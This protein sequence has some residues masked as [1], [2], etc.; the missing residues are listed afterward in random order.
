VG[1][2]VWCGREACVRYGSWV[3]VNATPRRGSLL[4]AVSIEEDGRSFQGYKN[5]CKKMYEGCG[6]WVQEASHRLEAMEGKV[7][8]EGA[9]ETSLKRSGFWVL[10][11]MFTICASRHAVARATCMTIGGQV[12]RMLSDG[13]EEGSNRGKM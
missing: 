7:D 12:R 11:R 6:A 2:L 3:F 13:W 8:R 4:C 9:S 5:E 1:A 10:L